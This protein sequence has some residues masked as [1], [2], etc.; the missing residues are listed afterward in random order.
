MPRKA[1]PNDTDAD[2]YESSDSESDDESSYE[3]DSSDSDDESDDDSDDDRVKLGPLQRI[4]KKL[5]KEQ[6]RVY[7]SRRHPTIEWKV[8]QR[9]QAEQ[10]AIIA[11]EGRER[12]RQE[13]LQAEKDGRRE[14][15][16]KRKA[17]REL[18]K[19]KEQESRELLRNYEVLLA[20]SD[21]RARLLTEFA[22]DN[23][24]KEK[25]RIAKH[26]TEQ[27]AFDEACAVDKVP[28]GLAHVFHC[29]C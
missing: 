4:S 28:P 3:S 7:D 15:K 17:Q 22:T 23:R 6:Q 12:Q 20:K 11:A 9:R 16:Q 19:L 13:E 21:T 10:E 8:S 18:T 26:Q 25:A 14:R 5:A 1:E 2:E 24:V 27:K 29:H